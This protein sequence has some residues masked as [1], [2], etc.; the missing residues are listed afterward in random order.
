MYLILRSQLGLANSHTWLMATA[1]D[2]A[3]LELCVRQTVR[4]LSP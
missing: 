2:S 4:M 1:L 3:A